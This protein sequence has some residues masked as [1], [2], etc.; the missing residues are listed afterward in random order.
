M[1]GTKYHYTQQSLAGCTDMAGLTLPLP[2]TS[3]LTAP[4]TRQ[5]QR[6]QEAQRKLQPPFP[7]QLESLSHV[8]LISI[9]RSAL[10]SHFIPSYFYPTRTSSLSMSISL[11]SKVGA[12][13][14]SPCKLVRLF[15]SA[16]TS[17]KRLHLDRPLHDSARKEINECTWTAHTKRKEDKRKVGGCP[18][19][20]KAPT[21]GCT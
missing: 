4:K 9:H 1:Q 10:S 6:R 13:A 19:E 17:S 3:C 21:S 8:R 16:H 5:A 14:L 11:T 15:P 18:C 12:A 20:H 7:L 2:Q